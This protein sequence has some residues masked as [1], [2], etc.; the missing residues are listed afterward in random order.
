MRRRVLPIALLSVLVTAAALLSVHRA[1]PSRESFLPALRVVQEHEKG[2][3]RAVGTVFPVTPDEERRVGEEL[4]GR[5]EGSGTLT[6]AQRRLR[7]GLEARLQ[8]FGRGLVAAPSVRRFPGRYRFAVL[9]G[10]SAPNAMALPGGFVY[11]TE[12]LMQLTER[13][14][15]ALVFVLGHEIGH[16]ELGH[17]AAMVRSRVWAEKMG[18][19]GMEAPAQIFRALAQMH[20]SET[21]ELESDLYGLRLMRSVGEDPRGALTAMDILGHLEGED[22]RTKRDPGRVAAEGLLDYFRTHPG[23]WERRNRIKSEIDRATR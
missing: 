12:G 20:F 4:A 23:G 9:M 10:W 8:E 14:P 21:Q 1:S 19:G 5:Y 22:G 13:H 2:A 3:D 16:V 15:G 17:C 18:V 7:D 11:V 6:P